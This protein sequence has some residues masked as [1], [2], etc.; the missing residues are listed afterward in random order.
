MIE[1]EHVL[2]V[3]SVGDPVELFRFSV[4]CAALSDLGAREEPPGSNTGPEIDHLVRGIADYWWSDLIRPDWCAA[5][6]SHWI[7]R[8]LGLPDWNRK[9]EKP[10]A[11]ALDGHPFGR[12]LVGCKQIYEWAQT[13]EE[14]T[15]GVFLNGPEPGAI[16]IIGY[17]QGSRQIYQHTGLVRSVNPDGS[18]ETIEGNW[19]QKV[20]SRTMAAD[21]PI[22]FLAWW[23]VL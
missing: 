10:F 9:R 18:F 17:K 6:V 15:P 5:A 2:R 21:K 13:A 14:E 8:G 3:S 1:G 23:A 7:R 12:W 16:W 19:N 20:S 11:P 22:C 4:L